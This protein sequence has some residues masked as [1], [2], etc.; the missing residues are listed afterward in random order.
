MF[1]D[2]AMYNI[3]ECLLSVRRE[4][5]CAYAGLGDKIASDINRESYLML[6]RTTRL[7]KKIESGVSSVTADISHLDKL[8]M[9]AVIAL[10]LL[11][12]SL[13]HAKMNY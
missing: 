12:Y 9:F 3:P 6:L 8:L 10:V 1:S 5:S 11:L 2:A 13:I 7:N 4:A